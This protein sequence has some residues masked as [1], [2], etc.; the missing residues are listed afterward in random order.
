VFELSIIQVP[1]YVWRSTVPKLRYRHLPACRW[2]DLLHT[3]VSLSCPDRDTRA[4]R[5]PHNSTY[6]C[7][8]GST[9][10]IANGHAL[11]GTDECSHGTTHDDADSSTTRSTNIGTNNAALAHTLYGATYW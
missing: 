5:C 11:H 8:D 1:A 4:D 6:G 9:N 3:T 7:A 2:A 10:D